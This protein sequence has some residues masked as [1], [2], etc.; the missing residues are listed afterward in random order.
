MPDNSGNTG[1]S[2]GAAN[3]PPAL[4]KSEEVRPMA[5]LPKGKLKAP[6]C[7]VGKHWDGYDSWWIEVGPD[8][9]MEMDGKPGTAAEARALI[10]RYKRGNCIGVPYA[11][12]QIEERGSELKWH[13]FESAK[14]R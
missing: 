2:F 8:L 7:I 12:W 13:I 10:R 4:E 3:Q 5:G 6:R 1:L 14:K 11:L 9:F